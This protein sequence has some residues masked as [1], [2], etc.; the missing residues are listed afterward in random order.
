MFHCKSL[1]QLPFDV[2]TQLNLTINFRSHNQILGLANILVGILERIFPTTIDK[3]DKE[4]AKVNGP[5]PILLNK[6]NSYFKSNEEIIRKLII[7]VNHLGVGFFNFNQA[8][9]V[10]NEESKAL[11]SEQLMKLKGLVL[12]AE[13][14]KG[15]QFDDVVVFNFFNPSLASKWKVLKYTDL[16]PQRGKTKFNLKD[17]NISEYEQLITE[18]K[19]FYTIVT[20]ARCTLILYDQNIPEPFL[21]IWNSHKLVEDDIHNEG[22][23]E[24]V[25]KAIG[26]FKIDV[27]K[28]SNQSWEKK[29]FNFYMNKQYDLAF[30][31]YNR[32][33]MV[34]VCLKIRAIQEQDRAQEKL[35]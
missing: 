10:R 32:L 31:C 26:E 21:H 2:P 12:T 14:C 9:I 20:R 29:G 5:L 24:K 3:L 22:T 16:Y 6:E 11:L 17:I 25:K 1:K 19:I 28:E 33:G 34:D 35:H 18:L 4:T 30:D 13:E 8:I 7:P 27:L 23:V 15:L